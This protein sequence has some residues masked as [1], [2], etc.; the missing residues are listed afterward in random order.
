MLQRRTGGDEHEHKNDIDEEQLR[1]EQ[2][3][4]L[5][6][7]DN[8]YNVLIISAFVLSILYNF[9]LIPNK[10]NNE[11]RASLKIYLEKHIKRLF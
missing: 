9:R 4:I 1:Y 10:N 8:V 7:F 11:S 6:N 3:D 2:K 5:L